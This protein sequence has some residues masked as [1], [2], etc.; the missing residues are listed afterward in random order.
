[1][2]MNEAIFWCSIVALFTAFYFL[3]RFINRRPAKKY[4]VKPGWASEATK[5]ADSDIRATAALNRT[6]RLPQRTVQRRANV[7]V[8]PAPDRNLH[9]KQDEEDRERRRRNEDSGFGEV[10]GAVV[11]HVVDRVV[12][13]NAESH[14][15]QHH[16]SS[17]S[18]HS[19]SSNDHSSS[20]DHHADSSDFS[21]NG[22]DFSGGGSSESW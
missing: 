19:H 13:S 14:T 1:M 9:E 16:D 3:L 2:S 5:Y 20:S 4:D 21:G 7:R 10:L 8:R 22:G 6:Q 12:E 17:I 15:H 11:G 18:S